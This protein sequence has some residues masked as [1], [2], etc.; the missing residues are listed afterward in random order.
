MPVAATPVAV[1]V[2][3]PP[4]AAEP[5]RV[6]K[7]AAELE[8]E[9]ISMLQ[10]AGLALVETDPQKWRHAYDRA[11][12][13]VEPVIPKRALRPPAPIEHGLLVLVETRKQ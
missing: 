9:R 5:I 4:A 11:T 7:P 8:A 1:P 6:H 13:L 12:A 3:A 2:A 10:G